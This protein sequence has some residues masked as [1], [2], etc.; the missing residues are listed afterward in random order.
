MNGTLQLAQCKSACLAFAPLLRKIVGSSP[1]MTGG[2][3]VFQDL[4]QGKSGRFAR[5]ILFVD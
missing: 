1:T 5:I 2:C 4:P 3:K